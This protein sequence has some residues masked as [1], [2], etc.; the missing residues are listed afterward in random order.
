MS[1]KKSIQ[2]LRSLTE[3]PLPPLMDPTVLY[4]ASGSRDYAEPVFDKIDKM[5]KKER[6][7]YGLD[8]LGKGSSRVAVTLR[9]NA[10]EFTSDGIKTLKAYG[11]KPSGTIKTVIKLALNPQG[12]A[13]NASEIRAWEATKSRLFVPVLDHSTKNKREASVEINGEPVPPQY[14]NWIQTI[15]VKPFSNNNPRP[16]YDALEKFFGV[17]GQQLQYAFGRYS[18]DYAGFTQAIKDW[19][20]AYNLTAEEVGNLKELI[21]AAKGGDMIMGDLT[22]AANWGELGG[23]L[24]VLDYGFDVASVGAYGDAPLKIDVEISKDGVMMVNFKGEKDAV[25]IAKEKLKPS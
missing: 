18:R 8:R 5:N 15:E 19:T 16:W 20:S 14:S 23:R 2:S 1:F 17:D 4:P 21:S 12:V 11:V 3:A 7:I 13:Q 22:Q 10:N 6:D 9:V 25:A 24:F